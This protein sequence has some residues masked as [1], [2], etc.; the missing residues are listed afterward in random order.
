MR[1]NNPKVMAEV[2]DRLS[3]ATFETQLKGKKIT[4]SEKIGRFQD[5]RA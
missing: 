2:I 1:V 5:L 3:T 4:F